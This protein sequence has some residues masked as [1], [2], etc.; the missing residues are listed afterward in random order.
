MEKFSDRNG[1][2]HRNRKAIAFLIILLVIIPLVYLIIQMNQGPGFSPDDQPNASATVWIS[3]VEE[4][5]Y[6]T[7]ERYSCEENAVD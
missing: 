1:R 3:P 4:E 7:V 6:L 2:T 5:A